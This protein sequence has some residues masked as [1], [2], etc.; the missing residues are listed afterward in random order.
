MNIDNAGVMAERI[1]LADVIDE[2]FGIVCSAR[3]LEMAI[4]GANSLC[5]HDRNA[6]G[7]LAD[8]LV[9]VISGLSDKLDE[10]ELRDQAEKG[11]SE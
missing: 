7:H 4:T 6:L 5:A 11:H 10:Q 8:S 3:A 9:T 1:E 2:L